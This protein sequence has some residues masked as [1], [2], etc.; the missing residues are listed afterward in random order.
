MGGM[1]WNLNIFW[2]RQMTAWL[3][4]KFSDKIMHELVPLKYV[5]SDN[6]ETF[7]AFPHDKIYVEIQC[8]SETLIIIL[9]LFWSF[10][11]CTD[12]MVLG[13]QT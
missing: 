7:N 12:K 11:H 13:D 6:S 9:L 1:I 8:V 10:K 5:K 4:S 3:T 2:I